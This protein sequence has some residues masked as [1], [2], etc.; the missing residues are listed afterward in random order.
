MR[1]FIPK[2][3][4]SAIGIGVIALLLPACIKSIDMNVND[5]IAQYELMMKENEALIERNRG[6]I[7]E[8]H[9]C[10]TFLSAVNDMVG[11]DGPVSFDIEIKED[12]V[13][14]KPVNFFDMMTI[15]NISKKILGVSIGKAGEKVRLLDILTMLQTVVASDEDDSYT[16]KYLIDLLLAVK[17]IVGKEGP[18][19]F[20]H[21]IVTASNKDINLDEMRLAQKSPLDVTPGTPGSVKVNVIGDLLHVPIGRVGEDIT[22]EDIISSFYKVST[23]VELEKFRK[24][25]RSYF[26][27]GF[28]VSE[29]GKSLIMKWG[30]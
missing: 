28:R 9:N 4:A 19:Y 1:C 16:T 26:H 20:K 29:D 7:V 18:Y 24:S 6:V 3:L 21:G 8:V 13:S 5:M 15:A 22:M 25:G 30:S 17:G 23:H 11:K 12:V 10:A 14:A 2:T 27:E